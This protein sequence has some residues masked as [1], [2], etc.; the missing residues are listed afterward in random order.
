MQFD[1]ASCRISLDDCICV[2]PTL[3]PCDNSH[4]EHHTIGIAVRMM[5]DEIDRVIPVGNGRTTVILLLDCL[6]E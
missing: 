2:A 5:Q 6:R 4:P 3:D 1:R